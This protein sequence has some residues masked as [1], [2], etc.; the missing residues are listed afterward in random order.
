M[1]SP[2]RTELANQLAEAFDLELLDAAKSRARSRIS[3]SR[4]QSWDLTT[5]H[6]MSGKDVAAKLG[7]SVGTVYANKNQVLNIIRQEIERL[8]K[9][10]DECSS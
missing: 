10:P 7:I 9:I 2:A 4:W 3:D 1:S 5:N 6:R 8:E